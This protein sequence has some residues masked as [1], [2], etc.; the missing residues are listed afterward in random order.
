MTLVRRVIYLI[1]NLTPLPFD[2]PLGGVYA[3][4]SEVL[5]GH[6]GSAKRETKGS[7]QVP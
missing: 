5:V 6:S 2:S 4:R 7:G 3:E 1:S